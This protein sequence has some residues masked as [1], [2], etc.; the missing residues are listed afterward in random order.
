MAV[1]CVLLVDSGGR[2]MPARWWSPLGEGRRGEGGKFTFGALVKDT[3]LL[4]SF[5][6]LASPW[7]VPWSVGCGTDLF[8][9]Q[10]NFRSSAVDFPHKSMT[11]K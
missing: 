3:L 10:F 4:S 1:L 8:T 11:T 9:G 7:L 2:F 6:C 5:F